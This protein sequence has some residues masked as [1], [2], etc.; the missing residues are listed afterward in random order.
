MSEVT[1]AGPS[2]RMPKANESSASTSSQP[3]NPNPPPGRAPFPRIQVRANEAPLRLTANL[4]DV[5]FQL[6]TGSANFESTGTSYSGGSGV[7]VVSLSGT[8]VGYSVICTAPC[9]A[10]LPTG[11]HRLAL[12]LEGGAP[13]EADGALVLSGS[14]SVRGEYTSNQG[15]RT[16]GVVIGLGAILVGSAV[17]FSGFSTDDE[18]NLNTGRIY[19]G[20]GIMIAGS[21]AWLVM[22]SVKDHAELVV[23]P[24][25]T[26]ARRRAKRAQ[27]GVRL[28]PSGLVF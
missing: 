8:T 17:M 28:A 27:A 14:S 1:Y 7:G 6:R 18:G 16:A 19:L 22:A 21:I 4:P 9:E 10:T 11:S 20:G 26:Q 2:S 5:T 23:I 15:T 24:G 12:S 25:K 3:Q 13:V